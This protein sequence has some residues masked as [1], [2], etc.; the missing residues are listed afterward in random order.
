MP[1]CRKPRP[2]TSNPTSAGQHHRVSSVPAGAGRLRTR[3]GRTIGLVAMVRRHRLLQRQLDA[4]R[5]CRTAPGVTVAFWRMLLCSV[6]WTVVLRVTERPLADAGANRDALIGPASRSGSTSP[7]S[8][9][10]SPRPRSPSAEFIGALTP[11]LL[12]PLGAVLFHEKDAHR[13]RRVSR[14]HLAGRPRTGAV[15]RPANRRVLVGRRGLDRVAVLLWAV[16]LLTSRQPAPGH[17]RVAAVMAAIMPIATVV[18]L[19]LGAVRVP[20]HSR[21][22]TWRSVGYIVLLA[23]LT[24]TI[25]H[26]LIVFAQKSRCRSASSA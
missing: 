10:R 12:V 6:I 2:S 5:S 26:G 24:G 25:A 9:R 8:S 20:G 14:A 1:R 4:G 22:S 16:Y 15:Q 13:M 21:R 11:L 18:T 23:V 19:P 7:S 17:D 3:P